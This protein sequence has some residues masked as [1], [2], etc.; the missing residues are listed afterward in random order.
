MLNNGPA[1]LVPNNG[2]WPTITSGIMTAELLHWFEHF[3][4]D[5]L[6][7]RENLAKAEY[8]VHIAYTFEDPLFSDWFQMSQTYYEKLTFTEFMTKVC[9]R[10]L[11]AG[12]EKDLARKVHNTKQGSTPFSDFSTSIRCDNL[13]LKNTKYHLSPA[14]LCNQIEAN[15]SHKLLNMYDHFKEKNDSDVESDNENTAPGTAAVGAAAPGANDAATVAEAAAH[16]VEHHLENFVQL[17]IRLD[18]KVHEESMSHQ[19][20]AEDAFCKPKHSGSNAGLSDSS[21]HAPNVCAQQQ[22]NSGS[23][24]TTSKANTTSNNATSQGRPPKLTEHE[25]HYL[26]AHSG[27][28]KCRNFYVTSGHACEFPGRDGYMECTMNAVNLA[29][30]RLGLASLPIPNNEVS[31]PVAAIASFMAPTPNTALLPFW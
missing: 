24:T 6:A 20:E 30:Q 15:L 26:T 16:K 1:T 2:K 11:V 18:D 4:W 25:H 22:S 5:Y 9:A 23:S 28:K 27:C 13:L 7:N 31:I 8:V 12:W 21:W 29:C 19:K 17:L 10:W 14:Q 3:T